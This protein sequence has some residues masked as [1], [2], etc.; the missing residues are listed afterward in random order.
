MIQIKINPKYE[1]LHDLIEIVS[2]PFRQNGNIIHSIQNLKKSTIKLGEKE[3]VVR[4]YG[5]ISLLNKIAFSKYIAHIWKQKKLYT[6]SAAAYTR[7]LNTNERTTIK[8]VLRYREKWQMHF[9]K[10]HKIEYF[11]DL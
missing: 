11:L 8:L 3:V 2:R 5:I 7:M 10:N 4:C 6:L 1:H 9:S